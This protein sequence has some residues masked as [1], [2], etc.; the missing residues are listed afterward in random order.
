MKKKYVVLDIETTGLKSLYGDEVTCICAKD[1]DGKTF[2]EVND[3]NELYE[4]DLINKFMAWL[5]DRNPKKFMMITKNGKMFDIP[6]IISRLAMND[7]FYLN[8]G[9]ALLKY[10]H[11][12]L[13]EITPRRISLDDMA[14][15]LCCE[16]KSGTGKNA[17][18]LWEEK[19]FV[20]LKAY[21]M[22][23][24]KVTEQVYLQYMKLKNLKGN[25]KSGS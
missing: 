19:N 10:E 21:C 25:K 20:L 3:E 15:L 17:I 7:V 22:Q 8:R 4:I 14:K 13:Q 11:F 5:K 9:L 1:S 18:K 23:D 2:S 24:V 12:D 16:N 6:F